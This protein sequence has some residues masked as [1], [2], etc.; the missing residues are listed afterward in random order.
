[1]AVLTSTF[2]TRTSS[3]LAQACGVSRHHT[4]DGASAYRARRT[5]PPTARSLRDAFLLTEIRRAHDES[6]AGL[7]FATA[8]VR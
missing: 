6:G 2:R 8:P 1:M 7:Q 3:R 5:Q 4:R